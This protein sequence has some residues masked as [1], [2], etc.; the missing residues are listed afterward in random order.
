MVIPCVLI[1]ITV[2]PDSHLV[3]Q[4]A[5]IIVRVFLYQIT[6]HRYTIYIEC[7]TTLELRT[8]IWIGTGSCPVQKILISEDQ[9][10]IGSD[11][12]LKG[13]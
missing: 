13:S 5:F 2:T 10:G 3:V 11:P 8:R 4:R 7:S 6:G 9:N 12:S 1:P